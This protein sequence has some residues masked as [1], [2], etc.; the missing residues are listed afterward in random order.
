MRLSPPLV[1]A[2]AALALAACAGTDPLPETTAA[3]YRPL[4]LTSLMVLS[5]DGD[6]I[7]GNIGEVRAGPDGRART[8]V[9]DGGAPL[10]PLGRRMVVDA[11]DLRAQPVLGT[12]W[13]V[14]QPWRV[15]A[16]F[17]PAAPAAAQPAA[18]PATMPAAGRAAGPIAEPATLPPPP[19][20]V[21]PAER[22]PAAR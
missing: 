15:V 4:E 9:I 1:P 22:A 8:I 19:P 12:T 3:A 10:F 16:G 11:E 18:Q 5:P 7:L 20:T 2:A 14:G 17:E 13:L 21:P 6:H